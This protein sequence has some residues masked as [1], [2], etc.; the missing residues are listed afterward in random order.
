MD[1]WAPIPHEIRL[2]I[3]AKRNLSESA[4]MRQNVVLDEL[5]R[6]PFR[7]LARR[8]PGLLTREFIIPNVTLFPLSFIQNE[9]LTVTRHM[10]NR[11][12]IRSQFDVN[13]SQLD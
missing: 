1:M 4:N 5:E 11:S 8:M 10:A 13:G 7:G 6:C 12:Q 3:L 2:Y 9:A